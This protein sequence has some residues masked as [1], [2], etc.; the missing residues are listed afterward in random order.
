MTII[1]LKQRINRLISLFF[2]QILCGTATL[3]KTVVQITLLHILTAPSVTFW[4]PVSTE[5]AREMG[6][7][8]ALLAVFLLDFLLLSPF[9]LGVTAFRYDSAVFTPPVADCFAAYKRRRYALSL[10]WRLAKLLLRGGSALLCLLPA[11]AVLGIGDRLIETQGLPVLLCRIAGSLLFTAGLIVWGLWMLRYVAAGFFVPETGCVREALHRSV[12]VT[13]RHKGPLLRLCLRYSG[14]F[15]AC[16]LILPAV[17]VLP[18]F[19]R[20][21]ARAIRRFVSQESVPEKHLL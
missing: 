10:R 1:S 13:Y 2:V 4:L 21:L 11:L 3:G 17:V 8:A 7:A 6:M 9:Y 20:A 19:Y 12:Q 18:L 14:G 16:L 15:L 5:A